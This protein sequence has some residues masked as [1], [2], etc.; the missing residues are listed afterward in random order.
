MLYRERIA[1]SSEIHTKR[2]STQCGRN[3]EFFSVK[4]VGTYSDHWAL[5]D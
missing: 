5:E 4:P 1:V 3:V 2:T